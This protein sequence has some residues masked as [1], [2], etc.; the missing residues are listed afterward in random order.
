MKAARLNLG[1]RIDGAILALFP[2]WGA[3]RIATRARATLAQAQIA[4]LSRQWEG[5]NS[6]RSR[7]GKWMS[8]RLSPDSAMEEDAKTLRER[9][10]ELYRNEPYT[11]GYVEG[12][13]SNEIGCGIRPQARIV[14]ADGITADRARELNKEIEALYQRWARHA[15]I[16]GQQSFWQIQRQADRDLARFGEAF[17]VMNDLDRGGPVPVALEV[18]YPGRVETPPDMGSDRSVRL[19]VKRDGSG[20]ILGYY[21]RIDDPDD[22]LQRD[23]TY[24]FVRAYKSG[25]GGLQM[26]HIHEALFD[27]AS[28]GVPDVAPVMNELRDLKDVKE[29]TVLAA[30]VEA[31]VV[32]AI[33]TNQTPEAM[34]ALASQGRTTAGGEKLETMTPGRMYYLQPGEDIKFNSPTHA[35]G[36]FGAFC[37]SALRSI[38]AGLLYCYEL[39][40]RDWTKVNYSSGRLAIIDARKNFSCRRQLIIERLCVPVWERMF[41]LLIVKGLIDVNPR[42]YAERPWEYLRC[43]WLGDRMEWVDP[44]SEVKAANESVEG[45]L[46]APQNIITARGDDPE[47]LVARQEEWDQLQIRRRKRKQDAEKAAGLQPEGQE[48]QPAAGQPEKP[49]QP[50]A[51]PTEKPAPKK[52]A[53]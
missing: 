37:E 18:I 39:L 45:G 41:D 6:D 30:Q 17:V 7:A 34:A 19:G 4:R 24:K 21:V 31:C 48:G 1:Q 16:D 36:T 49:G 9:S 14:E 33:T 46:D 38:G 22:T 13:V 5:A 51:K 27:G 10:E 44:Q 43:Q 32:G 35:A 8:S 2:G 26:L 25:R 12:R 29:A 52:E 42:D 23:Q 15:H 20:M 40:A 53:A 3:A 28:R 47:E 50:K 11:H